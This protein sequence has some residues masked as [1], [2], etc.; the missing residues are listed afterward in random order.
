MQV[1]LSYILYNEDAKQMAGPQ[2]YNTSDDSQVIR[3]PHWNTF[4]NIQNFVGDWFLLLS[5]C[6]VWQTMAW[7]QE[8]ECS[9]VKPSHEYCMR[10]I[11]Q[12]Y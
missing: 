6:R 11:G 9:V 10:K 2:Q 7:R 3:V 12:Q 1:I 8:S 5:E 4:Q